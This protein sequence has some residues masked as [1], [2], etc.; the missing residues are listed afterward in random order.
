M[1]TVHQLEQTKEQCVA[2]LMSCPDCGVG[3]RLVD[4]AVIYAGCEPDVYCVVCGFTCRG[5]CRILRDD[6]YDIYAVLW[7]EE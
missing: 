7:S 2:V 3:L 4:D 5:I 1:S 6:N